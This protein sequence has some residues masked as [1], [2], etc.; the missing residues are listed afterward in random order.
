MELT[1]GPRQTIKWTTKFHLNLKWTTYS[2]KTSFSNNKGMQ[3]FHVSLMTWTILK[4]NYKVKTSKLFSFLQLTLQPISRKKL[5]Y[6]MARTLCWFFICYHFFF[7]YFSV[8]FFFSVSNSSARMNEVST[9]EHVLVT[10]TLT[11]PSRGNLSIELTSPSGTKSM[12]ATRRNKDKWV[13]SVFNDCLRS[14][15][16]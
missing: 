2:Y 6:R 15:I 16:P 11:H 4:D 12:L 8:F 7:S 14:W 10:V 5:L 9:L 1:C 13:H 3:L